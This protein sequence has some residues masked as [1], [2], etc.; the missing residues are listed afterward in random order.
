MVRSRQPKR[1]SNVLANLGTRPSRKRRADTPP[2]KPPDIPKSISDALG[3]YPSRTNDQPIQ[4]NNNHHLN[5]IDIND[6][7]VAAQFIPHPENPEANPP[8]ISIPGTQFAQ[9]SR[10]YWNAEARRLEKIK[11]AA[12][13]SEMTATYLECQHRTRNW[14]SQA[15]YLDVNLICQCPDSK[16]VKQTV[17]LYEQSSFQFQKEITFCSCMPRPVRLLHYGYIASSSQIPKTAFAIPLLQ[18]H[19]QLWSETVVASTGFV[20]ALFKFLKSRSDGSETNTKLKNTQHQSLIHD[21]DLRK[22]FTQSVNMY[23]SMSICT[24]RIYTQGLKLSNAQLLADRCARCFGPAINE[25]KISPQEPDVIVALDGNFQHRHYTKSSKDNPTEEEYPDI[26]IKPSSM[27]KNEIIQNST[28]N[29]VKNMKDKFLCG[30]HINV[31]RLQNAQTVSGQARTA[32]TSLSSKRSSLFPTIRYTD[33]F[34]R[35]QWLVE[36]NSQQKRCHIK[37]EQKLELGRLLYYEEMAQTV[38]DEINFSRDKDAENV[39]EAVLRLKEHNTYKKKIEKQREKIG[40]EVILNNLDAHEQDQI[41]KIWYTKQE[42]RD[43]FLAICKQKRPLDIS[44]RDGRNSSIGYNDKTPLL[45]TLR[46]QAAKLKTK[47]ENYQKMLSTYSTTSPHRSQP[48]NITYPEL[49]KIDFD[50]PFWNDG[51]F[52][53]GREPWAIDANTQYGMQQV[54]YLDR[55]SEEICRIGWEVRRVMRW[56]MNSHKSLYSFLF[57]LQSHQ[58]DDEAIQMELPLV[59]HPA[60]SSLSRPGIISILNEEDDEIQMEIQGTGGVLPNELGVQGVVN[61]YDESNESDEEIEKEDEDI[62]EALNVFSNLSVT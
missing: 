11:W 42:V 4:Q 12:I 9:E 17:N 38:C 10:E 2:R 56:A 48:A 25:K 44:R 58:Y 28:E 47:L 43:Q 40:S 7:P 29:Q 57:Q 35:Q 37:E 21:R 18:F 41:L 53:N 8:P 39:E 55:A 20:N 51:L 34:L 50:H 14:T 1:D 52:T 54:A 16:L 46:D 23:R 22:Q 49:L 5:D 3:I 27:K 19:H 61:I 45:K 6:D 13:E 62:H 32:L 30:D 24:K 15:S 33:D 31:N 36:R 59:Q 26:F 60:L